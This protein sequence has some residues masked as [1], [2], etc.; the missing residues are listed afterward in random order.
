MFLQ[1][2]FKQGGLLRQQV[3]NFSNIHS[4]LDSQGMYKKMINDPNKNKYQ[5]TQ[6]LFF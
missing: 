4:G 3:A 5:E 6:M 1:K 2:A